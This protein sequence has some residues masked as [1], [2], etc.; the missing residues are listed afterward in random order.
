M[1]RMNFLW[2]VATSAY[3]SEG[4]YNGHGE[5][6][7]NWAAAEA[8]G[9]V[10]PSGRAADFWNRYEEDF[11]RCRSLGLN[12]FRLG[13]E[14]SRVQPTLTDGAAMPPPFDQAA[15]D[16]YAR[17]L[18]S[19]R[20][21]GLEPVVTLHHFVHPAWLGADAW[22]N[23]ETVDHFVEFAVRAVTH[24]NKLLEAEGHRPIQWF[25]T[26]N[27]PNMLVLNT[28]IGNQFP[29][30]VGGGFRSMAIAYNNILSAHVRVYNAIHDLYEREQWPEPNVTLNNYCSDVYWSD[31]VLLDLLSHRERN[32]PRQRLDR[33]IQTKA[34][35]FASAFKAARI[36]LHVDLSFWFGVLV[37]EIIT[38]IGWKSFSSE[39]FASFLDTMEASP[40]ARVFDYVGLDYYDPFA[41]HAFRLP[42]LWDHEFKNKSVRTWVMNAITS[43][44]WD[45]RVLPAGL[46]FFCKHYSED[47]GGRDVLI[48]E[49]GMALRR[50]MNNHTTL[51]RDRVTR[52]KFLEL[53]VREVMRIVDEGIPLVGYLHWSLF[54]NYEW[55]SYTPRFGLFSIDYE[56]GTDRLIEDHHADRA[57]ET[58]ARLIA[59]SRGFR[60]AGELQASVRHS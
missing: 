14:W 59:E 25:I 44:W 29:S 50:K 4:G 18:C 54:D 30:A 31:K 11:E 58:Y 33:Y 51:R 46:H 20:D 57:S 22:L 55:G 5:P 47:F 15:L 45:W 37:K 12:A 49:N 60:P 9:D 32:I 56:Q 13:I 6:Q 8:R 26:I 1:K 52:S 23:S 24:V 17:M 39:A 42:V 34:R 48:A 10:V 35:E 43:K 53:H 36:P 7:T 3:Q 40:R 38:L 16:H 41:A 2:G 21:H 19:C 27:E 28:Y